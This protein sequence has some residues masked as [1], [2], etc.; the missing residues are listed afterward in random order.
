MGKFRLSAASIMSVFVK[1]TVQDMLDYLQ[2]LPVYSSMMTTTA[3]TTLTSLGDGRQ[4]FLTTQL[5]DGL[6]FKGGR[7]VIG[8]NQAPGNKFSLIK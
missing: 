1:F 3:M 5:E 2:L 6:V 8:R 4:K 7:D